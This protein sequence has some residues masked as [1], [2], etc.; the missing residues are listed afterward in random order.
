MHRKPFSLSRRSTARPPR[1]N[2]FRPR[3]EIFETRTLLSANVLAYHNGGPQT[4]VNPNE[5]V[6]TPSN[7]N[8]AEFGKLFDLKLDGQVFAQPLYVSGLSIPGQGTH[9]VVF[10]ATENDSVY[11]FDADTG[12]LVW[13]DSFIDPAAGVTAV[14]TSDL[15]ASPAYPVVGITSAP[16][17][18]QT[19]NTLYVVA[20]TKEVSGSS[21]SYVYRLHALNV[22]TG[23][24]KFRGPVAIQAED[25]GTGVGN[26]GSGHVV[27]DARQQDQRV[28]LLLLNGVVYFGF[29]SYGDIEPYHG[30]LLGYNAQTLKQAAVFDDTPNGS[31]G[32]I[33]MSQ[34]SPA[35]DGT[36]IY[37]STGN[38]T[39]DTTLDAN[40]FPA[41]GD[42]GDAYIKLAADPST[43][44][45][46]QNSNG[47]GL[48]VVDYFT[49]YNQQSLAAQD[50]D[51]GSSGLTVLP[52]QTGPYTHELV[53]SSKDGT[54]YV[55]DRDNMGKFNSTKNNIIQEI[56]NQLP[57]GGFDTPA[58]FNGQVYFGGQGEN[59]KAYQVTN[60]LL[61]NSP[62]S[63]SGNTLANHGATS[64]ISANGTADGV[65]SA[66]ENPGG[67]KPAVLYAYDATNLSVELYNSSQVASRDQAG[68]G[69]N[70]VPPIIA[71]GKVFVATA[72]ELDVYGLLPP[73]IDAGFEQPAVG[74]G[75]FE[76]NPTSS[77]WKFAGSSGI[78]GND[79]GFTSGNPPAPQGLQVAFLQG[80]S[81]IT[82]TA[83][84]W[85]A[86]AYVITFD[87]AQ[88]ANLL[89]HQNFNVLVDGI[90]VATF[91][92]SGTSYQSYSTAAFTVS[93]G[94]VTITFQ[95]LDSAGGDNTAFLDG[96]AVT[97]VGLP[98]IGDA[99]F[100]HVVV[101]AGT[102]QYDP[103]GSAWAFS[104]T[105]GISGNDSGFTSGNS[106]APQGVQVAFLQQTGTITQAVTGWAA[107]SY[108]ITFDAAQRA[109]YQNARQNFNVL[110]D[111]NVVSTFTPSGTSYQSYY[112]AVFTVI[113][114]T[115]TITFQGLNTRRGRQ[116]RLP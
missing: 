8:S 50:L 20:F 103:T 70:F 77:A 36:Y 73:I 27:F 22:T 88:R 34:G 15:P 9:N 113:A 78:A 75:R 31:E 111:G 53:G 106:P 40:G 47:W 42:Y 18:D 76:Y 84:G 83:T 52:D 85:A 6:L 74:A 32:G 61:A 87:A 16:V 105:S 91:T 79:S 45:T 71:N 109:N 46:N 95:G 60:G 54:I 86:G 114:G 26:D 24:E 96:L 115:H 51:V 112:S 37:L 25:N 2:A 57:A 63:Q 30:W 43:S 49:P 5:T 21:T 28:G 10:V 23:A 116:H 19:T 4:G 108:V 14:P 90:L 94:P 58:Y 7:V 33:W 59:L 48:K 38:G 44:P 64:S 110:V 97:Q 82:Q 62:T 12:S 98:S 3:L 13:H 93:G 69:I 35:T 104:G 107:G 66:Q 41:K 100:E 65:V 56:D 55:I 67:S 29:A 89:S 99:G 80:S 102:F 72:D 81:S 68:L 39:F 11:A 101:G 17:I 1:R 92:P